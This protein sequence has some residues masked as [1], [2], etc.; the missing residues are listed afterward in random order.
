MIRVCL[1]RSGSLS[2]SG[3]LGEHGHQPLTTGV[4][5]AAVVSSASRV[6][7]QDAEGGGTTRADGLEA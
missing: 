5:A 2:R 6:G 3:P 4:C 7:P 1:L